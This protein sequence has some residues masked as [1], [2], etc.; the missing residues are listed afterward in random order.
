MPILIKHIFLIYC[1]KII[2]LTNYGIMQNHFYD[3]EDYCFDKNL[4]EC[5]DKMK[6][7]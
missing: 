5:G 7:G 3:V 4:R 1:I 6:I 2:F